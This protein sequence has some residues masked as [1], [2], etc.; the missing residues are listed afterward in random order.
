MKSSIINLFTCN[1][2]TKVNF[3]FIISVFVV[4]ILSLILSAVFKVIFQRNGFIELG[5]GFSNN[6]DQFRNFMLLIIL[7]P[8]LEEL[9]FR[10]PLVFKK[11]SIS[12]ALVSMLFFIILQENIRNADLL[13]YK[14]LLVLIGLVPLYFVLKRALS[15][16]VM[17]FLSTH[18]IKVYYISIFTFAFLHFDFVTPIYLAPFIVLPQ[19][20]VGVILTFVRLKFSIFVAIILH[21][22]FNTPGLFS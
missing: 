12:L 18:K 9:C 7:S 22:L 13:N 3:S 19:I 4:L 20:V 14:S 2:Q 11:K 1:K 6:N 10:L 17:I 15:D 8:F 5:P 16:E 21:M